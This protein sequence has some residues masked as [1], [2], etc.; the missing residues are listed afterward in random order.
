VIGSECLGS[1][2]AKTFSALLPEVKV[3]KLGQRPRISKIKAEKGK[4]GGMG[5]VRN[6]VIDHGQGKSQKNQKKA[7]KN[8]ETTN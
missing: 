6:L 5:G 2:I 3:E 8:L 4:G 7:E 1:Y